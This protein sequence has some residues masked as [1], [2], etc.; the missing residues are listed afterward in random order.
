MIELTKIQLKKLTK[1]ASV[2]LISVHSSKKEIS[3]Q[4]S[5]IKI[6]KFSQMM[7]IH[8][9]IQVGQQVHLKEQC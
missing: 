1:W 5:D 8:S 3:F 4:V 2:L 6:L 9:P 7:F